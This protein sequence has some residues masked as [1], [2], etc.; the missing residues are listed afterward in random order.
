MFKEIHNEKMEFKTLLDG[1]WINSETNNLI[2]IKSPVDGSLIGKVQAMSKEEVDKSISNAKEA[3]K[4]WR[5][6]P[7][8]ERARILYN[9]AQILEDNAEEVADIL[10]REVAKDRKS[11][12]SETL[13]TADLIRFTA[14][15]AKSVQGESIPSDSFPGFNSNKISI[16]KREPLGVVLAISPFNYPINLAA[17]KIGPALMGGNTVVLKPAT[18]GSIAGLYLARVF[19]KAGVP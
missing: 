10:I 18:Q 12:M 16:V 17:S 8:H 6:T 19:E 14:D 7:V 2:E 5:D 11:A 9:A 15:V 4:K 13:R 3:Q 1:Q